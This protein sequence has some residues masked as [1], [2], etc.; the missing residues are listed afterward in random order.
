[1]ANWDVTSHT[2]W[3][4][5]SNQTVNQSGHEQKGV[6]CANANLLIAL[7]ILPKDQRDIANYKR[8]ALCEKK[9]LADE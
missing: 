6:A 7:N 4:C 8:W 2:L 3:G 5:C 9:P 1:M